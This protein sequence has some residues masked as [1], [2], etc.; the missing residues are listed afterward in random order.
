M[1][2]LIRDLGFGVRILARRPGFAA[3]AV[4]SLVLGIG[5]NTAIFTLLD[6]IFLRPLPVEDLDSLVSIYATRK[7]DA[8][9]YAGYYSL[10]HPNY[11]DLLERNRSFSGIALHVW[12]KMNLTGGSEPVR[13][14]GAFTT[15]NYFDVLGLK[16]A[17]GRFF[18]P[19]EDE[20]GAE[21]VAV[22]S[23]GCWSRWFGADPNIVG[24][25]IEINGES[26]GVV[27]VA[28][29]G[30]KGTEVGI[31]IDFWM[32]TSAFERISPY[33]QWFRERGG[34][35]FRGVGRLRQGV[36]LEQAGEEMMRLSKQLEEAFP[37]DNERLGARLKPLLEGTLLPTERPRHLGYGR[38]LLVA[39]ALI[40]FMACLNVASLLLV[41]GMERGREISI[42]QSL[43]A[44]RGRM[45]TQL[46]SEN[47]FLFLLGGALSL[48]MARWSLDLLW[49]FRP[50]QFAADA[51]ELKLDF[52]IFAFTLGTA[53]VSGLIFGLLPAFKVSK[54][55]LVAH[56]KESSASR[57]AP[58]G[59][60]RR[61]LRPRRLLVVAQVAL[62]LIAL[63]GAGLYLRSLDN[64][65]RIDLGFEAD[66]LLALSIAPGEQ[67]FEPER[68]RAFY[69]RALERV[70]QIPGVRSAAL[71]ENRLL[72][73]AI[74]QLSVYLSGE[75]KPF[76]GAG[77][78]YFRSNAVFPGFFETVGIPLI[79]GRDFDDTIL[80]DG[81]LMAIVNE[82][83]AEAAWPGQDPIGKQFHISFPDQPAV[84]VIGIARDAKYRHIHE[85][86]QCFIYLPEI[87]RH[88]SA[89]TL[90]VR[91]EGDPKALLATVRQEVHALAPELPIADV[92]TMSY[93]VDE[94]LWIER[95]SAT[96]LSVFGAL[97]LALATLGVYGVLAESVNQRRREMGVRMAIGAGRGDVLRV[98]VGEG[99][100]MVGAGLA[101]GL[102]AT[103]AI[104]KLSASVASQLHE[105]S[106]TDPGIYA[107]A[108]V[109]LLAVALVAFLVPV[110]RAIRTDPV[111]ALR[112]E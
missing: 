66:S 64:A 56:L 27:G 55:D 67:G 109:L 72:R 38:I 90:H 45:V 73:G 17:T 19:R 106:V 7:N 18:W 81:P 24:S 53:L 43:G 40:L 20:E 1:Q 9:E 98:V 21:A 93:F 13:G 110:V 2:S 87:Q 100:R 63:I 99:L 31:D 95:V 26:F 44:S 16:P 89:M 39:V 32:P 107:G 101:L 71:S 80:A 94:A 46:V 57:Q 62:A 86:P 54:P 4:V 8:G 77:R 6:A 78:A 3:A 68:A 11:L 103:F 75:E 108:V 14:T 61:W 91:A 88:A 50:P 102:V 96:L 28:P 5:L 69:R 30:F 25:R 48:P 33:G 15:A 22:L 47:L 76:E 42:R 70:E 51:L 111:R 49:R 60:L 10:S 82:T 105:V 59:S 92:G 23:H 104:M 85:A 34:S 65:H 36:S 29:R 12:H 52:W 84:E 41:R 79:E 112:A 58:A 97:A 74:L 37:V 83:M 35:V